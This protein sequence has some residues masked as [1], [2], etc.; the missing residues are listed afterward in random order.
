MYCH[1]LSDY[2]SVKGWCYTDLFFAL[3]YYKT[4]RCN[5]NVFVALVTSHNYEVLK[6]AVYKSLTLSMVLKNK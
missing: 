1:C 3:F 4:I 6:T 5:K 2:V